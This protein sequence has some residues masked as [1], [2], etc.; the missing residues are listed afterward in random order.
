MEEEASFAVLLASITRGEKSPTTMMRLSVTEHR[1]SID[2]Y[3][4]VDLRKLNDERCISYDEPQSE[5]DGCAEDNGC[6]GLYKNDIDTSVKSVMTRPQGLAY[7][8]S[9]PRQ[10]YDNKQGQ[11]EIGDRAEA[12]ER[13]SNPYAAGLF[14]DLC[15]YGHVKRYQD[16]S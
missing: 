12:Q 4:D 2:T 3:I 1:E 5:V 16:D 10:V 6:K 7:S 14:D 13:C 9:M 15:D 8:L 11:I